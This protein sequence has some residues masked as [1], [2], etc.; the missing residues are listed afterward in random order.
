MHKLQ[1]ESDLSFERLVS[2]FRA[3]LTQGIASHASKIN[4]Y[5]DH[6]PADR[7]PDPFLSALT[8]HC[9]ARG[10]DINDGGAAFPRF[11]G[12]AVMGLATLAD[13][14]AATKKL[15]FDEGVI[16]YTDLMGAIDDD[17]QGKEELRQML[18]NKAP[19]YGNDESFV[20]T[21]AA[22]IV[23]WAAE[24]CLKHRVTGGG[25]FVAAMAANVQNIDAGRLV[26]ATPDGRRAFTPLSDAASPYFGRDLK[27]PTAFLKSVA[28]PDYHQVLTGSVIN[29][30]FDP[31]HF[32]DEAST[33][34]FLAFTHAFVANRIPELQFNF[35]SNETLRAAQQDPDK[36]RN[37]VVRV[38]GF[39]ARFIELSPEVQADIL[40]RRA[41]S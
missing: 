30:R 6:F 39:S 24:E 36:Y 18:V 29:M 22:Q 2:L 9:I 7:F 10:R 26:G 20:D 35:T 31:N 15:V 3:E 19:K 11:H 33:E 32:Q 13:S 25:R 12:I 4:D 38:S 16:T 17:F 8:Q 21:I 5:I 40:R 23:L 41:H 37:L 14:L 28:V 1:G 34:R 27:G